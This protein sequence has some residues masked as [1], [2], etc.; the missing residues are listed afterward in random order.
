L[1]KEQNM[2]MTEQN[3]CRRSSTP[4]P[5]PE[6]LDKVKVSM[7]NLKKVLGSRKKVVLN[8]VKWKREKDRNRAVKLLKIAK[9]NKEKVAA[10]RRLE[11][12]QQKQQQQ[13][14]QQTENDLTALS[15]GIDNATGTSITEHHDLE[16]PLSHGQDE[17]EYKNSGTVQQK[18]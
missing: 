12:L 9:A 3:L 4:F 7:E 13:Q 10:A 18:D 16:K 8:A 2:L 17:S 14:L 1:Y 11:Y 15:A 6:R 5:Q